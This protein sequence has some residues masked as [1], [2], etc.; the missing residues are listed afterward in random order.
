MRNATAFCDPLFPPPLIVI[1][2]LDQR[3][4]AGGRCHSRVARIANVGGLVFRSA[5]TSWFGFIVLIVCRGFLKRK[6]GYR[7]QSRMKFNA[8]L[9]K[10]R[11]CLIGIR[12]IDG[13]IELSKI[14]CLE[15]CT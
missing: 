9:V 14:M 11:T 1:T 13:V 10:Q 6:D 3:R 2:Y 12:L 7:L 5:Y 8:R 15:L 4:K